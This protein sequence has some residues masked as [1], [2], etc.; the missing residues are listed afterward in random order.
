M[1]DPKSQDAAERTAW[2]ARYEP[3]LHVLARTEIDSRFQ[4]KFSASDAVQQTMLEAWQDWDKFRGGEEAQRMAWLRQILAH[5]LAHLA[6]HFAGTKKRDVAREVSIEQSLAQTS[7]RLEGALAGG[8]SSPS[9][10]AVA[11]EQQLMLSQVLQRLPDD[12]R[13]V[14]VL[15][16]LEDLA[17]DDIARRMN[18]KPGAIRMLWV[19]ALTRLREE[20]QRHQ[21]NP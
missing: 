10:R 2:L 17:Y 18:R 4:G 6:R 8:A 11:N 3:W 19:R 15:R 7:L 12:Y 9:Q 14:I 1:T 20:V 16:N 5:Q 21:D 13:D